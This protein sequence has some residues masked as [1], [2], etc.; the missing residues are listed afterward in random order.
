MGLECIKGMKRLPVFIPEYGGYV[1]I[2]SG[3]LPEDVTFEWFGAN[4]PQDRQ[5]KQQMKLQSVEM[6]LKIDQGAVQL[7][8]P[9]TVNI[10]NIIKEVLREGGWLDLEAIINDQSKQQPGGAPGGPAAPPG[11]PGAGGGGGMPAPA[12]LQGI[13][14]GRG[15]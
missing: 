9:P 1:E 2:D 8:H 15:R 3:M 6:A 10:T 4:G 14:G 7:G 5:Q 13:A 11:V 12:A